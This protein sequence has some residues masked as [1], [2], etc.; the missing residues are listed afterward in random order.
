V[1][2]A[3]FNTFRGLNIVK[4]IALLVAWFVSSNYKKASF[5]EVDVVDPD[6]DEDGG[7]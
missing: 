1:S 7:S 6:E 4:N 3:S 2:D 5:K